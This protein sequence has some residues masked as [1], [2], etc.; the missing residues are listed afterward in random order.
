MYE[1]YYKQVSVQYN[2]PFFAIDSMISFQIDPNGIGRIE[3]MQAANFLK[4]SG[5]SVVV[6]SRVCGH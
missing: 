3:A 2:Q 5:L 4:K 1:A 6:L